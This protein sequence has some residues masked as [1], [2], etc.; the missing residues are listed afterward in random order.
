MFSF[1]YTDYPKYDHAGT[2]D[3]IREWRKHKEEDIMTYR[4]KCFTSPNT[5]TMGV[6]LYAPWVNAMDDSLEKFIE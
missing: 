6:P 2:V 5:G 1:Q 4:E 3:R